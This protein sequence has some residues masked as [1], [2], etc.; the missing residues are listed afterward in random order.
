[1]TKAKQATDPK[2]KE[3]SK[4]LSAIFKGF[5]KKLT[6]ST[7]KDEDYEESKKR[8]QKEIDRLAHSQ[9]MKDDLRVNA[10]KLKQVMNLKAKGMFIE[11]A[12]KMAQQNFCLF[13]QSDRL[14]D[15]EERIRLKQKVSNNAD[16][17][18]VIK[19]D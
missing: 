12:H 4:S 10:M 14:Q 9:G 19:L 15:I 13:E 8:R 1:M 6:M 7:K 5:F 2:K 11:H 16:P 18:R 17:C 3:K